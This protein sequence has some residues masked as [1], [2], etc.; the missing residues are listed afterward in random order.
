[1]RHIK[2][3]VKVDAS[4]EPIIFEEINLERIAQPHHDTLVISLIIIN[5]NVR[6]TLI[7]TGSSINILFSAAS[8]QMQIDQS[9][10]SKKTIPQIGF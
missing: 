7:D 6:K 8:K 4:H 3:M 5:F 9:M 2:L 10:I 1:M